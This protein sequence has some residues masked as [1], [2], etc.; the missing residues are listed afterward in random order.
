MSRFSYR[1]LASLVVSA[2][3]L[4][5]AP[6]QAGASPLARYERGD[7]MSSSV[8]VPDVRRSV[9]GLTGREEVRRQLEE[10]GLSPTEADRRL[11]ALTDA[12]VLALD[13]DLRALPAGGDNTITI[14][15][16]SAIIIALL[17]VIFL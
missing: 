13:G 11:A 10:L 8:A 5:M 9:T 3:C 15:V 14:G 2:G 7:A 4:A 16:G 6:S 17:L 12:E 1:G